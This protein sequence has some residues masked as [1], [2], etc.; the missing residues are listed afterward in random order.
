M[1][2]V[3]QNWERLVRATLKREQLRT[4]GQ[5]HGRTPSGIAGA[6]PPSLSRATNIE[7]ILQAADEIQ[8]EDPHVAR[9]LCEQAYSMAQNL[10]PSSDGRGV[11]QFKTGLMSVI[12]Q[13]LAKRDGARIDRG[14]DI[15]RLWKF[16]ELYKR[17]HKV[18]DIEREEQKWRESGTF[19]V[20]LG[21]ALEMKKVLATLRA[22]V[23]VMEALSKDADPGG[24]GGL[25]MEE[26]HGIRK[27]DATIS[28]ELTPYNIVP[29]EAPSFTNVIG[30]FPEVRGAMS[31]IRYAEHFPRLPADF[32]V[33]GQRDAD[34]FDL[35]EYVFGF[36]KD[37]VRNQRENV[38]LAIANAQS[39]RE[40]PAQ[41]DQVE[42]AQADPKIDEK[43]I[44]DVFSKVLDN[45]IK[46]CKYLRIRLA[47]NSLEAINRERKLFL[48]SLYFLIWGEAANVR[49][50]P[51]CI[52]YLFHHM[53]KELDATL[54]HGEAVPAPSCRNASGSPSFLE[55]IIRPIYDTMAAEA[56]RNSNGK[57]AHSAWRNYDDFNE[58]F[59]S[60]ACFELRWPM[61]SD[62]SFLLKPKKSKRIIS[63]LQTT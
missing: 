57:A 48:I 46:W 51:E 1:V 21:D 60:P 26:L 52:C 2:G 38:V 45:Y 34:M 28:G 30:V 8:A 5:G 63:K 24:V 53:A 61:R 58:Y 19:S 9:I 32:E 20:N 15:E 35:L 44:N 39:R 23:E 4:A 56:D 40:K 41:A 27:A 59:W 42:P 6:V 37:N 11:L 25:I 50:L 55:K 36:Q 17:R 33:S 7:A 62:S 31:A 3:S 54:D 12:K 49:F 47:Y 43:P 18:D 22:L 13:K 10:D 29:L 16:Y 14:R